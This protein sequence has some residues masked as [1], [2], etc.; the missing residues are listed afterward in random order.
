MFLNISYRYQV[1]HF[2]IAHYTLLIRTKTKQNKRNEQTKPKK[3]TLNCQHCL[4]IKPL[5]IN[6]IFLFSV[7]SLPPPILSTEIQVVARDVKW[8]YSTWWGLQMV[9]GCIQRAMGAEKSSS[10]S[11]TERQEGWCRSCSWKIIPG[12]SEQEA[13]RLWRCWPTMKNFLLLP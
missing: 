8:C 3:L 6:L 1:Y 11:F 10:K 5:H 2:W 12:L 4:F 9:Q 7:S 13:G